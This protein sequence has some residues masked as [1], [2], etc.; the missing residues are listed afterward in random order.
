[1][2]KRPQQT[3]S[4]KSTKR[5]PGPFSKDRLLAGADKRT[6]IGRVYRTILTSMTDH[7]GGNPTAAEFLLIQ[8]CALKASR[9][10]LMSEAILSEGELPKGADEKT[11]SWANSMRLDLQTLGLERRVKD[12]TPSLADIV[13]ASAKEAAE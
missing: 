2:R 3:H 7:V 13:A 5:V 10:S 12:I 6:R 4:T 11:I 8:A 1:M 9:L